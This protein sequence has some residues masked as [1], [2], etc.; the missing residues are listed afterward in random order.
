MEKKQLKA[1]PNAPKKNLIRTKSESNRI[2]I[3]VTIAL[4]LVA[5]ITYYLIDSGSYVATVDGHR[6]SKSEYQFFL[7]QKQ[8]DY[9]DKEGLYSK[10]E[11]EKKEYWT[12]TV[13]GQNPWENAKRDA[14]EASKD[15]M[16]QLIKAKEK[17]IKAESV[18]S[19]VDSFMT[20]FQ[21]SLTDRQFS[22]QIK[23]LYKMSVNDFRNMMINLTII[24]EY[25]SFYLTEHY[26]AKE[27]SDEEIKAYY[28]KDV[29]AFDQVDIRYIAMSKTDESGIELSQEELDAKKKKAEE[30]L[31]KIK[32]GED[33]D[34]VITEYTEETADE[35]STEPL[36]KATLTYSESL[37]ENLRNFVFDNKPGAVD[38]VDTT[39]YLYV[40]KIEDRTTLEDVKATV[41]L[42]IENED[43]EAFYNNAIDT[44]GLE[45]R[46]NITKNDRVYDSFS[47]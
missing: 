30:A 9:E 18:K 34:K 20:S 25:K 15:Y 39:Y 29:K 3:I 4:L 26:T 21:G 33:L 19:E 47:Y 42:T 27:I 24:D 14:L 17:A 44:W 11:Q 7:S 12:K 32:K 23:Q 45:A 16:I 41:K 35:T 6:I 13:D 1:K 36:G 10:T 5:A 40:V 31:D 37:T 38:I 46:Y 8:A 28:E 2:K 22:D 43:K